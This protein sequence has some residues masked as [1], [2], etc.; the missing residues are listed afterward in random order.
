MRERLEG[1]L[2]NVFLPE[3]AAVR[4]RQ[5]DSRLAAIK[6]ACDAVRLPARRAIEDAEEIDAFAVQA[7]Q[8]PD[9]LD[10]NLAMLL[11][12]NADGE[13]VYIEES[14][15][16]NPNTRAAREELWPLTVRDE[17]WFQ[18]LVD[19]GGLSFL[20]WGRSPWLHRDPQAR[21]LDPADYELGYAIEIAGDEGMA[22]VL[23]ALF[24]WQV[25]QDELYAAQAFLRDQAG[26]ESAEVFL[27][28]ESGTVLAHTDTS[29]YG[30]PVE[31]DGM[32]KQLIAASDEQA[33]VPQVADYET[34]DGTRHL[35]GIAQLSELSGRRWWVGVEASEDELFA[36]SHEFARVLALFIG[37][38]ALLLV[39]WSFVA[40]RAILRPV[41][42]LL[43]ATGNVAEG[44]LSV[45]VPV[46]GSDELA[47]LGRSFNDMIARLVESRESLRDAERQAAWGEMARQIAH[48]I[49]N[50]LTPMRMS[51]QMVQRA[52]KR[53][54]PR[55]P[56]LVDRLARTVVEQT[57]ALDRIASDFRHFAGAP[58]RRVEHLPAAALV[59]HVVERVRPLVEGQE[60]RFELEL[61]EDID[62]TRAEQAR[63]A[64]D[65]AEIDRL[66]LNL[67]QNAVHAQREGTEQ[68]LVRFSASLETSAGQAYGLLV[69]RVTDSG[70]GVLPE[71]RTRLF[72]PYFT[73][74][75]S[76]TGLGLAI[77]RKIAE[78]HGGGIRL[79]SSQPGLTI[80]RVELPLLASALGSTPPV[81]PAPT[82]P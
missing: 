82:A 44:D 17:P 65:L 25:V 30:L 6:Q 55:L 73:T 46:R 1:N 19:R 10:R 8:T 41:R 7:E 70:P 18:Q 37:I 79:E 12:A 40:S 3:L 58:E 5:I 50:P 49:K 16:R 26:F 59:A 78:S 20:P 71:A 28:N 38:T 2:V 35:V 69:V 54:D 60:S 21:S 9:L 43:R 64:V 24:R 34:P 57:S 13:V 75:S 42:R 81:R 32:R 67:A 52:V 66:F 80:F 72:E 36:T 48:E 47:G 63:V 56:E 77:C 15:L 76:G 33:S 53:G 14:F 45:R 11:L 61:A 74:K 68:A 62:S 4:A 31:Q 23:F 22:G 27:V 51:A 29:R 39:L